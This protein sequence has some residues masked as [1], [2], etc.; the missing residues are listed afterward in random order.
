MDPKRRKEEAWS[1]DPEEEVPD[2]EPV[3]RDGSLMN[4]C[5]AAETASDSHS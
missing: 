1:D 2:E 5:W 3:Y 4:E